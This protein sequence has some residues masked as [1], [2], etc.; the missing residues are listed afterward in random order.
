MGPAAQRLFMSKIAPIIMA[1][2]PRV[3]TPVGSEDHEDFVQD[4]LAETCRATDTL[5]RRGKSIL[6]SSVAH[7]ALQ[8][9]KSGG[10]STSGGRTDALSPACQFAGCGPVV[11]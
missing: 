1:T 10:R 6:P 7:Y 2:V 8:R 5:E 11:A 4:A 9:L 3:V